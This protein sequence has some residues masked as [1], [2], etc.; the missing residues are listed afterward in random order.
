MTQVI[1]TTK[2]AYKTV[3]KADRQELTDRKSVV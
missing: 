3:L 2:A 1:E